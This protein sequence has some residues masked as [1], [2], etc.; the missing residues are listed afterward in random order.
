MAK[1]CEPVIIFSGNP[2]F[3][4]LGYNQSKS[5]GLRNATPACWLRVRKQEDLLKNYPLYAYVE[6]YFRPTFDRVTNNLCSIFDSYDMDH[7]TIGYSALFSVGVK[8]LILQAEEKM[9][10][11]EEGTE[12][13]YFCQA[14]IESCN[15]LIDIAHKFAHKAQK[16]LTDCE[17]EKSYAYFKMIAETSLKI[18]ENPPQTFYEGLAMLIFMRE[19]ISTMENIGVSHLGHV[20]R[21]LGDLYERDLAVGRISKEQ[22]E[23]LV[24]I[25]MMHTDIK[26]DLEHNSWPETSTCIQLG[27]CD[28]SGK[29]VF[30]DVT[31]IFIEQHHRNKLVNPKLNCRYFEKS[32]D[33]YIKLLWDRQFLTDTTILL[34]STMI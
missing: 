15:A 23:E 4:E 19:A 2:F 13:Y 3:F 31:R 14:T 17:D 18:Q 11:F 16:L 7:H 27:G 5:W 25:W 29:V 1:Y 22:A 8:G 12:E 30:N 26:F 32:P 28:E 24:T 21:L 33:E 34:L 20:D 10:S 6:E 9:S